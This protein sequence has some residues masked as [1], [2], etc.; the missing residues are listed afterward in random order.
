MN[1]SLITLVDGTQEPEEYGFNAKKIINTGDA[2]HFGMRNMV[3][4]AVSWLALRDN[5]IVAQGANLGL[6]PETNAPIIANANTIFDVASITKMFTAVLLL[7]CVEA[8]YVHL[9]QKIAEFLPDADGSV[10]AN[11]TLKQLATHT[12]GLPPWIALHAGKRGHRAEIF[13]TPLTSEPGTRYAY[14][15]LGYILLGEIL[16]RLV[17]SDMLGRLSLEEAMREK[18]F[19]PCGM[20]RTGFNP[21]ASLRSAIAPTANCP[22]R[23]GKILVGEVHDANAWSMGGIA[24]HAGVFSTASDLARFAFALQSGIMLSPSA[25]KIF[26]ENQIDPKIGGHSIG[27]FTVPNPMLPHGD[28][29]SPR[30]FGHTGFTGTLFLHDPEHRVTLILLTNRVYF[31]QDSAGISKIRRQF[32]NAVAGAML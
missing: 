6:L 11:L 1:Q 22:A 9:G 30:T 8:G 17:L 2:A 13:A 12:S 15:D 21:A 31:P 10:V 19:E 28:L 24:G 5:V 27:C 4:P 18:I 7:Q 29:L 25:R 14:S 3:Y 26:C 32:A 16:P 23:P 20:A